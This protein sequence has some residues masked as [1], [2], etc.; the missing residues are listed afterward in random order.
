[1]IETV[2]AVFQNCGLPQPDFNTTKLENCAKN[3]ED[4]ITIVQ[5]IEVTSVK[6]TTAIIEEAI[7]ILR[8]A[9]ELRVNCDFSSS[10]E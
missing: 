9:Q 10:F 8:V 2:P 1:L 5:E 6:N 3:V 4:L 7:A